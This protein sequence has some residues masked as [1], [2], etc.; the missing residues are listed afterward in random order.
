MILCDV[1]TQK[2]NML[3]QPGPMMVRGLG[4][5]YIQQHNTKTTSERAND[6]ALLDK[7][8]KQSAISS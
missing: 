1:R 7:T 2:I 5:T 4:C 8:R 3:G 6:D